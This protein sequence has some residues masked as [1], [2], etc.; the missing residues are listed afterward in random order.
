[1]L[2]LEWIKYHSGI[3]GIT[4]KT[5]YLLE[6]THINFEFPLFHVECLTKLRQVHF[7]YIKIAT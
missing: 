6:K 5:E 1:M 4:N 3:S 2:H 7:I